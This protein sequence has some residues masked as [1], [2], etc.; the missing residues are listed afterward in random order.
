MR[1]AIAV[2]TKQLATT[3]SKLDNQTGKPL[4]TYDLS[5]CI[6]G[7]LSAPAG[8][9]PRLGFIWALVRGPALDS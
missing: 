8:N 9:F 6:R 7:I 1:R 3:G 2:G 5:G 4:S